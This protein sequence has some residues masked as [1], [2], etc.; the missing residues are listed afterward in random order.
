MSERCGCIAG[1]LSASAAL[2]SRIGARFSYSTFTASAAVRA[3]SSVS[4]ATTATRSPMVSG[5]VVSTFSSAI[6]SGEGGLPEQLK[7]ACGA[8]SGRAQ[9][10]Y[11]GTFSASLTSMLSTLAWE[12]GQRTSAA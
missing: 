3:A 10:R 12:Y 1:A 4:A 6:R 8:S 7:Y 11:P 9:P 5:S 2:T